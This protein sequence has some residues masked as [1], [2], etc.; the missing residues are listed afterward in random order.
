MELVSSLVCN[1]GLGLVSWV[2]IDLGLAPLSRH[3]VYAT[4]G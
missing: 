4:L 1:G 2:H 3:G